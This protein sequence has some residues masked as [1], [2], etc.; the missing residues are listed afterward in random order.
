MILASASPRRSQILETLG[1]RPEVVPSKF[2]EDLA[3][4]TF[5]GRPEEYAVQTAMEKVGGGVGFHWA[6]FV[7]EPWWKGYRVGHALCDGGWGTGDSGWTA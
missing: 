7:P 2:K 4:Q 5:V 1:L 3:K 6:L